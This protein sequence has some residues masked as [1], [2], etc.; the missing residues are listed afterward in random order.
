[1]FFRATAKKMGLESFNWPIQAKKID[2]GWNFK[3]VFA[4]RRR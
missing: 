3:Q 1:M 2:N 4:G